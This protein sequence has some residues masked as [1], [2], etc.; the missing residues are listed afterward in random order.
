MFSQLCVN[1]L[2][3]GSIYA[4]VGIGFSL[5]YQAQ[6]FFHFTHGLACSAGAYVMFA[7]C[8]I[9]SPI[10]IAAFVGVCT[11]GTL[12]VLLDICIIH[13]VMK[14]NGSALVLLLAS[15]GAYLIGQNLISMMFGD[16]LKTL[17]SGKISTGFQVFEARIT[18][19]QIAILL[20]TALMVVTMALWLELTRF[21]RHV[22][23]LANDKHLAILCGMRVENVRYIV[24]A[25]G[26]GLAGL[27]GILLALD[28]DIVPTMGM[29]LLLNG[30]VAMIVGGR[31]SIL[32]AAAGGIIVGVAQNMCAIWLPLAWQ[33][34]VVFV[35]L[36]FFLL[37]RPCGLWG[38]SLRQATI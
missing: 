11:A 22:R 23:A 9:G 29:K 34:A 3:A 21:G 19:N 37:V 25:V 17:S 12:G 7:L 8:R 18:A 24:M 16:D 10:L 26:S 14:R 27:A 30:V 1:A 31:T 5:I 38:H 28:Q 35:I 13:P 6:G 33:D 36:V 15:I 20:L 2:I 4:L 32:G